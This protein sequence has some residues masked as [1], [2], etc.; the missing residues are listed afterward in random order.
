MSRIEKRFAKL[1]QEGRAG[2]VIYLTAGDPD[3]A[4]SQQLFEGLAGAGADL[5]EIGMPFSDPMADGPAIQA[6]G[7]RAL[8]QGATLRST[9]AMVRTLRAR[10]NDTPLV[11]MG[12]YNPI[13]RYGAEAF[14]RDAVA[15]GVDGA[16]IV[17]LPPEEDNELAVPAR[18]AGLD[19]VRL[20]TPTSD[21]VRLPTIVEHASGFVYY[22][23]IAGITGTRSAEAASVT[24][25]VERLRRFTKLPVAV[26][27]GIRTPQQ[28]AEI[29]RAAD[30]AVVGSAVVERLALNLDPHGNAKPGLVEAVLGDIRALAAGVRGARSS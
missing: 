30:A 8:K 17:D 20:A 24:S 16:I 27:F 7:L 18:A 25:A 11:L 5:I 26:G 2:L 12:Y 1:R 9:L 15:A 22:V 3:P 14:A 13:Y 29:A 23:A 28:A 10:D 19:I 4:T 6:A 21:E